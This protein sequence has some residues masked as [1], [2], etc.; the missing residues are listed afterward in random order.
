MYNI[1]T[2]F[3]DLFYLRRRS[4]QYLWISTSRLA[5]F[6]IRFEL[7]LLLMTSISRDLD[8]RDRKD[9]LYLFGSESALS[10][11]YHQGIHV[12]EVGPMQ[13]HSSYIIFLLVSAN[14]TPPIRQLNLASLSKSR[15]SVA[16][17]FCLCCFSACLVFR[18]ATLARNFKPRFLR[19]ISA[20]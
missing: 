17:A 5:L 13:V 16:T 10:R 8:R 14:H 2:T 4:C 15:F 1:F 19:S 6:R 20:L 7:N 3:Q 18:C 12:I 9:R 11:V